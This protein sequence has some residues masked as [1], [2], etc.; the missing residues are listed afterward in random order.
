LGRDRL[1][2]F[3][4]PGYALGMHNPPE[5]LTIL[6]FTVRMSR[7]NPDNENHQLGF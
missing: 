3:F 4:N 1:L 5:G 2:L 7:L 6:M